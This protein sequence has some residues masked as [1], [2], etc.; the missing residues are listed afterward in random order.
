MASALWR[1]AVD[2]DPPSLWVDDAWVV[3][4]ARAPGF[5]WDLVQPASAPP[6][7][8]ALVG[9][10]AALAPDL[11]LGA[12]AW[13]LIAAG[14]AIV[15]VATL[16]HRLTGRPLCAIVAALVVALDT[17]FVIHG[18]RVKPYSGDVLAVAV[19]GI[20]FHALLSRYT[21]RRLLVHTGATALG[22]CVS[23]WSLLVAAAT[24]PVLLLALWQRRRRDLAVAGAALSLAA[25]AAAFAIRI[26]GR[27]RFSQLAAFWAAH[28]LPADD[29]ARFAQAVLAL[30][31]TWL[32]RLA[33]ASGPH[34]GP[35]PGA[36]ATV[37][38]AMLLGLGVLEMARQRHRFEL[39][40]GASTVAAAM[41]GSAAGWLPIGDLRSDLYLLPF[42]A[43]LIAAGVR[44]LGR[45][46]E[47][48]DV[49]LPGGLRAEPLPAVVVLGL[50]VV[51]G[52]EARL[53]RYPEQP[54][55]PLVDLIERRWREGDGLAVNLHGTFALAVYA[56]WPV[57]FVD[58]GRMSIPHPE[59]V[60][61]PFTI[62]D[63]ADPGRVEHLPPATA[64]TWVLLCHD[65]PSLRRETVTE[66]TA[67]G[68]RPVISQDSP[69]CGLWLFERDDSPGGPGTL[70]PDDRTQQQGRGVTG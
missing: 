51:Q 32:E 3:A 67:S 66:M 21:A 62:L 40:A 56:S 65:L 68:W 7:F 54:A 50:L 17:G 5:G 46:V 31:G 55:A 43:V 23:T 29:P 44:W 37:L 18:A 13:P 64:R 4:L 47:R 52:A 19:Q 9:T 48:L 28:H 2:L 70:R 30:L 36:A 42:G 25:L 22:F 10:G 34:V 39:A 49:R 60:L 20:G 27:P 33:H 58:D 61:E 41:A 16:A 35:L 38:V 26:A 63:G 45:A 59:P 57:R 1:I 11:E 24:T 12:Q 69:G 6:L 14:L 53:P 8:M 15:A